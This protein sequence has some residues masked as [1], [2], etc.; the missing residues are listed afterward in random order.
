MTLILEENKS[1]QASVKDLQACLLQEHHHREDLEVKVPV[2]E[3]E[4]QQ[5]EA[6]GQ[7]MAEQLSHSTDRQ[8]GM[9]HN[10]ALLVVSVMEC[11]P[12]ICSTGD[13]ARP[14]LRSLWL[15]SRGEGESGGENR[16]SHW[17]YSM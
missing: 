5:M 4:C 3:K 6:E 11:L 14:F 8:K 2:L 7:S 15:A 16:V 10:F 9:S 12:I 13:G 17:R 1:L